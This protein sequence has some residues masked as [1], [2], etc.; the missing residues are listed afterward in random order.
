MAKKKSEQ[1][2]DFIKNAL[3]QAS[4]IW[5]GRAEC[6]KRARK[7]VF[8]RISKKGKRIYKY[9][10]KCADC[11]KWFRDQ[12]DVEVDHIVEIGSFSGDWNDFIKKLFARPVWKHLQVLCIGCHMKKTRRYCNARQKWRRKE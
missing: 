5:P 2:I 8:V 6:L 10:W 3:R 11:E 9:H 7:K 4:I 1:D 12:A